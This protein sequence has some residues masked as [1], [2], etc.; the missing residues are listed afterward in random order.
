MIAKTRNILKSGVARILAR[1]FW[2]STAVGA[3]IIK[4]NKILLLNFHGEYEIYE[5]E[6]IGGKLK[7]SWDGKPEFVNIEALPEKM[8]ENHREI[9]NICLRKIRIIRNQK[10]NYKRN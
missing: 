3:I 9:I 1:V 6:I 8:R 7:S 2:P 10:P 5:C 4:G